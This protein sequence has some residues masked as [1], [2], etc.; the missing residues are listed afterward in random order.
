LTK[1]PLAISFCIGVL[2]LGLIVFPTQTSFSQT[3][4]NTVTIIPTG[5]PGV[6]QV[7]ITDPDRINSALITEDGEIILQIAF[8]CAG[9]TSILIFEMKEGFTYEVEWIDCLGNTDTAPLETLP[10][11]DGD[12]VPDVDDKCPG[13]P[14][15]TSVDAE[16]CALPLPD[17]DDDGVPNVDDKCPGTP[18]LTPVD[19]EGCEISD[20]NE[21]KSCDALEKEN[22]GKAKGKDKAKANNGC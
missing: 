21:K 19:A 22:S 3:P 16:G 9:D 7:T 18:P 14:P 5:V 11:F 15:L 13:T 6:F 10:D 4:P 12:G 20:P 8:F 2:L 1:S 17:D